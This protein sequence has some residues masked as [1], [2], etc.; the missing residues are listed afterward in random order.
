MSAQISDLTDKIANIEKENSEEY[1]ENHLKCS[2]WSYTASASAVL[3]PHITMKHKSFESVNKF[4]CEDCGLMFTSSANMEEHRVDQAQV[5]NP[6]KRNRK[7]W[8]S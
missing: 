6:S 7:I 4:S 1:K 2:Q 5:N 8:C 3:K